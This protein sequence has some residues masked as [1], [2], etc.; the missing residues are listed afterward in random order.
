MNK[1]IDKPSYIIKKNPKLDVLFGIYDC[2]PVPTKQDSFKPIYTWQV[3]DGETE[4][5]LD[6]F[7]VKN[8]DN[9]SIKEFH[10]LLKKIAIEHF[11]QIIKKP[12]LVEVVISISVSKN[13]FE[14]VDVDNLA[15]SVL[16]GLNNIAFEDD[17]QV[18]SLIC[19]KFI[20][21]MKK[22]GILI[23]LTKLTNQNQGF[24]GDI[25]LYEM[26]PNDELMKIMKPKI[27]K[28]IKSNSKN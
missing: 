21:P 10:T 17:S 7:Y 18:V 26:K 20:H 27:K 23:G 1:E 14:S 4:K 22:N 15:K 8:P 11:P 5:T 24:N 2:A 6:E 19:S 3:I 12:S 16:D 28:I 9:N 13:R 25:T